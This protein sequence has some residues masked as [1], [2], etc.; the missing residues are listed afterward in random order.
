MI[1]MMKIRPVPSDEDHA[2]HRELVDAIADRRPTIAA[3]ASRSHL[4]WL[5][6]S[7]A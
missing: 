4:S 7:F 6:E 3:A 5:K 2:A 1:D